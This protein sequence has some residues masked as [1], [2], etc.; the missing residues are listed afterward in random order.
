MFVLDISGS[1]D[2]QKMEA[3]RRA[4]KAAVRGLDAGDRFKLIAFNTSHECF[5][6]G[7]VGFDDVTLAAADAWV[8]GLNSGGGTEL[9]R[10]LLE[11]LA[12]E[13][14]D[15]RLRTVL[16]ITD[17]EVGNEDELAKAVARHRGTALVFTVGID[18]AVNV[19]LL[20]RMARLGG[21]TC[22]LMTPVDDIE[23]RIAALEARLAEPSVWDVRIDGGTPAREGT[24]TLFAGR[25]TFA[26]IEGAPAT[27]SASGRSA[28]GPW[29]AQ[30]VPT[31]VAVPLGALWA[32]ERVAWLEDQAI[33]DPARESGAEGRHRRDRAGAWHRDSLHRICRR[34]RDDERRRE[35]ASP[36]CSRW[37]CRPCGR[38]RR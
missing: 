25:S 26:L 29:H 37:N 12:G 22:D 15:G 33:A 16:V 36:W 4:L 24:L 9:L 2:G 34:R 27:V 21:G 20:T 13:T 3:G 17:G 19:S 8:D 11:A 18:T 5:T 10:P 1:M 38:R 28:G 30:A 23:G 6:S 14:P 31:R 32:R 7:F 35:S